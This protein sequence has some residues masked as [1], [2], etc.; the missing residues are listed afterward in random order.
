M[1]FD[2]VFMTE[3]TYGDATPLAPRKVE[4]SQGLY[5]DKVALSWQD[6]AG[7]TGYEVWRSETN[8]Y[9]TATLLASPAAGVLIY[10]D[11]T[12]IPETVYYYWL[13]A[14]NASGVSVF[15]AAVAGHA[16]SSTP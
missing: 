4:A 1:D 9:T 7:A 12:A 5:A 15:S 14:R 3:G 2:L 6:S 10:D 11:T 13:K 16:T 8:D